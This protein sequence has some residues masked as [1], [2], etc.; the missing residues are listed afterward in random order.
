MG[1]LYVCSGKWCGLTMFFRD[2]YD[3]FYANSA[4][5]PTT[6]ADPAPLSDDNVWT[7]K[8]SEPDATVE[9][10]CKFIVEY[11]NSDVMVR[12]LLGIYTLL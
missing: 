5:L 6:H 12:S 3:I 1:A 9:D 2:T 4:L 10:I 8:E 11:M 7:L